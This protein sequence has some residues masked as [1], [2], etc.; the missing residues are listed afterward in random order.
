M[1]AYERYL[2]LLHRNHNA[3]LKISQLPFEILS[4]IFLLSLHSSKDAQRIAITHV[5]KHWREVALGTSRLWTTTSSKSSHIAQLFLSRSRSLPFE[6]IFRYSYTPSN[7]SG[8]SIERAIGFRDVIEAAQDRVQS[9]AFDDVELEYAESLLKTFSEFPPTNLTV[10]KY[11]TRKGKKWYVESG[12]ESGQV[13]ILGEI[14][15][16]VFTFLESLDRAGCKLVELNTSD[17]HILPPNLGLYSSLTTLQMNGSYQY[18]PNIPRGNPIPPMPT[19]LALLGQF[20]NLVHLNISSAGPRLQ[21]DE[22]Y[23]AVTSTVNLPK[24]QELIIMYINP[25]DV[26]YLLALLTFP[27]DTDV[28]I[29]CKRSSRIAAVLPFVLPRTEHRTLIN[30]IIERSDTVVLSMDYN[31]WS[32]FCFSQDKPS[33]PGSLVIHIPPFDHNFH[34]TNTI[35]HSFV[36]PLSSILSLDKFCIKEFVVEKT[37]KYHDLVFWTELFSCFPKINKLFCDF[38]EVLDYDDDGLPRADIILDALSQPSSQLQF[39]CLKLKEL[40]IHR[41]NISTY[42][43]NDFVG[44]LEAR[45][46]NNASRMELLR[47][48]DVTYSSF[49]NEFSRDNLPDLSHLVDKFDVVV[50][51]VKEV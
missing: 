42:Y 38:D 34:S 36:Q 14:Q 10:F 48:T 19:F 1:T 5:C 11:H 44:C 40:H 6:M 26:A 20:S 7:R 24:L 25:E 37:I 12:R 4:H 17:V 15:K 41:A 45:E 47:Y 51:E 16:L 39:P 28:V 30:G 18:Y 29:D 31:A 46:A 2:V 8:Q 21:S 50:R 22:T 32:I 35:L 23:P 13:Y 33:E 43:G 49:G 27:E 3:S 9:L